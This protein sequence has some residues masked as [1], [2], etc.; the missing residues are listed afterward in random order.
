MPKNMGGTV[1]KSAAEITTIGVY[2]RANLVMNSSLFALFAVELSTNARILDT[3]DSWK[4]FVTF[5]LINPLSLMHPL[6]ASSPTPAS[7][8]RDSPVS[9]TVFSA[10]FPSVM[11]P[12]RGI[13]AI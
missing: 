10:V 4:G 2:T 13:F 7:R 5:I 1:A 8:G 6:I 3:V 11:M 9:A 12:S